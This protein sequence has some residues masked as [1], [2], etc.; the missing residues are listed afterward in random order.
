MQRF[1]DML[2]GNRS[3]TDVLSSEIMQTGELLTLPPLS[4]RVLAFKP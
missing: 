4:A 3:C 1:D 2:G